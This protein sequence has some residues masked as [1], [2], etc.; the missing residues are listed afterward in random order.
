MIYD[1]EKIRL[2]TSLLHAHGVKQVV[3]CPGSRNAPILNNICEEG[4]MCCFPVTD[5]RSAGFFAL[6]L[7]LAQG[8]RPVAVCVT[9]RGRGL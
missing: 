3:A 5:E 4:R 6:G 7:S 1:N 9:R 8:C 2:L